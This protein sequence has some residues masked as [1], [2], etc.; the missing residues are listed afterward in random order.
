MAKPHQ[1]VM[2]DIFARDE[3]MYEEEKVGMF[4]EGDL[5]MCKYCNT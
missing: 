4:D 5:T 1:E 2:K 3:M